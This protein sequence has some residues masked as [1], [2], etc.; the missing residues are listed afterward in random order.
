MI[1]KSLLKILMAIPLL[2][3]LGLNTSMAG[4]VDS[5]LSGATF[6]NET[7]KGTKIYRKSGG[8]SQAKTD[9]KSLTGNAAKSSGTTVGQLP[10]GTYTNVRDYSKSGEPTL[11]IQYKKSIKIRYP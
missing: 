6:E 11:E 4:S 7:S 8:F 2:M 1:Y 10:D 5:V 3:V 9:F